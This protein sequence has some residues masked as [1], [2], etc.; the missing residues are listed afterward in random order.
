MAKSS[1]LFWLLYELTHE[2]KK[3]KN[4]HRSAF[5]HGPKMFSW[6][7]SVT[8]FTW[9]VS[10]FFYHKPLNTIQYKNTTITNNKYVQ[11]V[12]RYKV[13]FMLYN[14]NLLWKLWWYPASMQTMK[15]NILFLHP[16]K[17]HVNYF[18]YILDLQKMALDNKLQRN[19]LKC[20]FWF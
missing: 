2:E 13:L 16:C 18:C 11:Q 9:Y 7:S 1:Q 12:N 17:S 15:M 19:I 4:A 3:I 6:K 5:I 10:Q 14:I 8:I 20:E